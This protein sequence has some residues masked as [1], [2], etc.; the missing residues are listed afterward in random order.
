MKRGGF[1][2]PDRLVTGLEIGKDIEE[3]LRERF[4][5]YRV[6]NVGDQTRPKIGRRCFSGPKP[7]EVRLAVAAARRAR[8]EIR[9]AVAR[10]WNAGRRIPEPLRIHLQ[11]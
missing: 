11:R 4:L 9:F 8:G 3:I 5:A 6:R 1:L 2:G 10:A 7:G